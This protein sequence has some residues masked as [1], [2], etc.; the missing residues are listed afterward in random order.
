MSYS[1]KL[2]QG[3]FIAMPEDLVRPETQITQKS[4]NIQD[5]ELNQI[6][7]QLEA[8]VPNDTKRLV[9]SLVV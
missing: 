1:Q 5:Y 9:L 2:I 3:E 6:N 8:W 7:T 4:F